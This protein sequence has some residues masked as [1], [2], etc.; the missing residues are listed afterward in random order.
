VATAVELAHVVGAL[1]FVDAVHSAPH[2]GLDVSAMR[3]DLVA[4]SPYKFFGPHLGVL[5]GRADVLS[6]LRAYRVRPAGDALPGRFEIGTQNHEALAGLLGT[7]R[8]LE[9]IGRS[10]GGALDGADR[11]SLLQAAMAAI[12]SHERVLARAALAGLREVPGLHFYGIADPERIEERVP[13][14][15]FTLRG[16]EPREVARELARRAINVWDG[17]FYAW[18][19]VRRLGL[20]DAGGLVRA[21]FVHYNTLDEVTRLTDALHEIAGDA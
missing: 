13:T 4:C 5:Y 17:D 15:A 20:D 6:R 18:E 12:R 11:R 9:G 19:L 1:V 21:G 10:R 7:V 3:A 14:F 8:Y 16:H 2:I